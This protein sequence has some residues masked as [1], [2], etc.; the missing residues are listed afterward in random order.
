[1]I[2][3]QKRAARSGPPDQVGAACQGACGCSRWGR[4]G[5]TSLLHLL[6]AVVSGAGLR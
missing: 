1:M 4:L 6:F 2:R 3:Q 5:A